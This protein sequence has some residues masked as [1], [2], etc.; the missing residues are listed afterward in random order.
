MKY[1]IAIAVDARAGPT[2]YVPDVPSCVVVGR[3]VEEAV[4]RT[5][6]AVAMHLQVLAQRGEPIP[7]PKTIADR[8][9]SG[10]FSDDVR[11][12]TVDVESA[13]GISPRDFMRARRP[14]L[15]S[16]SISARESR[17]DATFLHFALKQVTERKD[18]VAFEH[19]C[20]K[21]AEKEICPNLIPQTGPT[22]G[23]DSKVD[24][25]TYPVSDSIAEIW[26]VGDPGRASKER[27]A[28]AFS[29]KR[30]WRA[31]ARD[32][33]RKVVET[34][35][36]YTM[37]YFMTNQQ[38]P[39]RVRG[40]IED[41]FRQQWG[42][43]V[44]IFD[45]SWIADKVLTNGHDALFESA[46]QVNLGGATTRRLGPED[47]KRE[48]SLEELDAQ[49]TDSKRYSGVRYQL[50]EDCLETA[51][52]ARGLDRPRT[53][54]DGRFERARRVAEKSGDERQLLKITYHRAWTAVC[55][56]EDCA[57]FRRQYEVA[58][59]LAIDKD[60]VW[61]LERVTVLWQ[62]G[63]T[64]LRS[65]GQ[66][67]DDEEWTKRTADLR[68]A[69]EKIG[70]DEG[71]PTS[72]LMA[73]TLLALITMTERHSHEALSAGLEEIAGVLKVARDHLDYPFDSMARIVEEL[74]NI[75]G[76]DETLDGLLERVIAMQ[77][78]RG[79]KAQEGTMRLHRA[80]VCLNSG[81]HTEAILQ[82]GK[83]QS[84]LAHGGDDDFLESVITTAFAYE[85]MGL[86]W[87][88]RA[89]F[90]FALH[91]ILRESDV[92]GELSASLSMPITR[93]I[94][95]E[96]QLGRVPQ[97]LCW[98]EL[99]QALLN[100]VD[101]TEGQFSRLAEEVALMDGVLAMVVLGTQWADLTKLDRAPA[102]LGNLG[103][104]VSRLAAMFALGYGDAVTSE[105]GLENPDTFFVKLLSQP[106]AAD[107]AELAD[108]G[109]R[110]PF[111]LR[112]T[113]FGCHVDVLVRE[114]RGSL[115]LGEAIL[116]FLE[117]MLAKSGSA[118]RQLSARAEL[119]VEIVVR[120]GVRGPFEHELVEDDVG[121][122]RIVVAHADKPVKRVD[123]GYIRSMLGLFGRVLEQLWVQIKKEDIEA[124]FAEER[125]PD[126][127]G[128]T[129]HLPFVMDAI[130]GNAKKVEAKH[131]FKPGSESL[132]LRRTAPWGGP[133]KARATRLAEER[134]A[135]ASQDGERGPPAW[136]VDGS[137]HRDTK[138]F[139]VVNMPLW[140]VAGWKGLGY[141]FSR[142]KG[143]VPEMHFSFEDIEAGRKIFRGWIRKFGPVD[144]EE[145]IGLTLVTGI[146]RTNPH[147]YKL[148]VGC[149]DAEAVKSRARILG[150]ISR[151]QEMRPPNGHN[152]DQFLDRYHRLGRYRIAPV[153]HR[154]TGGTYRITPEGISIEKRSLE[155]VPA[156][157][158]GPNDLLRIAL[159]GVSN[160]VVPSGQSDVPFFRT[161]AS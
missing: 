86:L 115:Y 143:D 125:A 26:Y 9:A 65:Q 114:G 39:D 32:D 122:V 11:W 123:E 81:R 18:E 160:P 40:E 85:A 140:D 76:G 8:K 100:G 28:F 126:R 90:A 50:A 153:G 44:R 58:E 105:T 152:L 133:A 37:A 159:K 48:H 20:R 111:S 102:V 82:A 118:M 74:V 96:I 98:V 36:G 97:V 52:L 2:V 128:L 41:K 42:L 107:V 22:G 14:D 54:V 120:N 130:F 148:V 151:I 131:W 61:D 77:A 161:A 31:K 53:E 66:L 27:W 80:S 101:L 154:A 49:I 112:T 127:A 142:G 75:A 71:R 103:L 16:D 94:W 92:S 34:G 45:R 113:L 25:E 67:E 109:M 119:R 110:W 155:I 99:H 141:T 55:W 132:A 7:A 23:G 146:D 19:F 89:N 147:S 72:T 56:Y 136:G 150:F 1:P 158:I 30:N 88:A 95:L 84:L 149:S 83:A 73:R 87:A 93:L 47:A 24:S 5:A 117:S 46:L 135:H 17:V 33:I 156:W 59:S 106:A 6:P 157:R 13:K 29:A 3:T 62:I 51:L 108:W 4:R 144:L 139:S 68:T 145:N 91:W 64:F 21:L 138:V 35:R 137:R 57:E 129:A 10:G 134:R 116:A 121:E 70:T 79:G 78:E 12:D 15:Y 124:L 69:L 104:D 60:N 38:V 63:T 43:D